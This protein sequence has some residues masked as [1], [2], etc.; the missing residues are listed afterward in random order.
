[1]R[2]IAMALLLL[3]ACGEDSDPHELTTCV[4]WTDNSGMPIEGM[5]EQACKSPP[6]STGLQCDTPAKLGCAAF[7]ASGVDGCCVPEAGGPIK[8]VECTTIPQ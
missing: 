2:S 4:G 7:E 1:M 8:F 5:C 6:Q 3:V